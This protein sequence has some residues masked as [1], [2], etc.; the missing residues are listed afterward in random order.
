M[1]DVRVNYDW[2]Y[3]G[4]KVVTME[5]RYLKIVIL[6]EAGAKI[7]QITYKPLDAELLWNN[8]RIAPSRVSINSHY[9]D[10]W[11]GGWDE[12]FP[13]DE[14]A[15]IEGE[16]Y[17]DHGELWTGQWAAEIFENTDEVGV[18]L[19]YVTPISAIEVEKTIRLRRDRVRIDFHHRFVNRGRT[20]F[21][22]LWK[23]HPAMAVSPQH[24]IDFPSIRVRLE[25]AFPGTLAGAPEVSDWPI[26]RTASGDVDLRHVCP[27]EARQLYFLY[28]TDMQG[29]WCALTNSATRLATALQFN[30]SIFTCCW[31]FASYGG[32]RNL[33]VA[34]LEP[35]T[36]YPLNF[37][38][39]KA[40]GRHRSLAPGEIL[41]TDV[42][43]IVQEG[44]RSVGAI[45][46]D[47]KMS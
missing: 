36:G 46:Q 41:E 47:G 1:S 38:A 3:R 6:P 39:M 20:R 5:N 16:S 11:S 37:E 26:I 31:L 29:N 12:L 32:W 15:V 9:D 2:S 28:G 8:P 13:N 43:F 24:R 44:L 19:R 30:P 40:S 7:W 4:L 27:E 33:N 34:V 21:P 42:R 22:F 14:I 25:P 35:C 45:D 18:N 17:P 23:L 10:V